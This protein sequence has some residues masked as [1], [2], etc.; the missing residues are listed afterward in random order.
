MPKIKTGLYFKLV[1]KIDKYLRMAD[2]L[3]GIKAPE[4][5]EQFCNNILWN[6]LLT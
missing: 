3:C 6:L 2:K 1:H 4:R 5:Y